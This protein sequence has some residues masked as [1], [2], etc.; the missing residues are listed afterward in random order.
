MTAI[1]LLLL[2]F[3]NVP[4]C[5]TSS[6]SVSDIHQSLWGGV[7]HSSTLDVKWL[8]VYFLEERRKMPLLS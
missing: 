3:N 6:F 1:L 5:F 8:T 2:L 4:L 7:S